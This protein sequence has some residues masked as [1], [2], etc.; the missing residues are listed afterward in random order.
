MHPPYDPLRQHAFTLRL[1]TGDALCHRAAITNDDNLAY[2]SGDGGIYQ[3]AL[4]QGTGLI[5]RQGDDD[6]PIL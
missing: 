4:I 3:S 5:R 1:Q 6:S 2:G